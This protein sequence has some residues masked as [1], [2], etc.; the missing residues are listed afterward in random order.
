MRIVRPG[1]ELSAP[2]ILRNPVPVEALYDRDVGHRVTL[3]NL[4]QRQ[5]YESLDAVRD[6]GRAQGQSE[7]RSE[8]IR[9]LIL[10]SAEQRG[11]VADEAFRRALAQCDDHDTLNTWFDR[12]ATAGST[13][14]IVKP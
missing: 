2:G 8:A 14:E 9:E 5:G 6:E 11:L 4:L 10:R 3:R 1:E 13:D 12:I 7:G